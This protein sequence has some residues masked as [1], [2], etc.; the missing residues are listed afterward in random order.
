MPMRWREHS[1]VACGRVQVKFDWRVTASKAKLYLE[2]E[3]GGDL[4]D[5]MDSVALP[6]TQTEGNSGTCNCFWTLDCSGAMLVVAR[7]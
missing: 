7:D 4:R 1:C 5:D 6:G 3:L 2:L